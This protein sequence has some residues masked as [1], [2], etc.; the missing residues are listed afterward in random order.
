MKQA[1]QI[2]AVVA[3]LLT[4]VAAQGEW[5]ADEDNKLEVKAAATIDAFESRVERSVPY[6]ED[7]Y[8]I[9]VFPSI[10]RLGFGFGGAYGKGIVIE[11]DRT[12]GTTKYWQ[13]TSGIQAGAKAFGMVLF[14]KDKA[15]LENYQRSEVQFLGQAGVAVGTVGAAGT[16]TYNE[17]VAIITLTRLG[18]MGEF[19]VSGAKF[20]YKP[21]PE[22]TANL[23]TD[24]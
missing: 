13:F 22:S 20:S 15:A 17:G 11:K 24:E 12:I 18:L 19:T 2:A 10:T 6:F 16:P 4:G 21:L 5:Q 9:A 8:A 7:A 1:F 14:F 3:W 23:S